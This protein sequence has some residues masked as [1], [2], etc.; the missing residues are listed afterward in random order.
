MPVLP[1]FITDPLWEQFQALLPERNITH[2]LGCHRPRIP[3]RVVFDKLL[4]RL[5]LGGTYQQHADESCSATTMRARRDEW[6]RA[7]VFEQLH[8]LAL[9]AYDQAVGLDLHDLVVDGCIVKAPCGGENT[10]RSPVDRGKS[11]LKRSVLV[12]G[13]G[14]PVGWV[15]A[16]AN[17][18][19]SP[20]LRPTLE[21][22]A[23]LG[24]R[25]PEAITV[26]LDAGYDSAG[27]RELLAELGCT[28][29]ITPRGTFLPINRTHRW[30]VERT[31]SWHNRGFATLAKVTDRRG[32]VQNAWVALA[33]AII[34]I[35]RLVRQ[36][37]IRYRW[38][39]R[40]ARCP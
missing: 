16:G 18:N 14:I 13:G 3:D 25:L 5:V 9:E 38:D 34:I 1:T 24:F 32:I 6:I 8:H 31:N 20:L 22:L 28:P 19:D 11:G 15:L 29:N 39:G 27:T 30:V 23:V 17:R 10:G 35:R 37:W 7:G 21:T 2:P 12:D 26:H 40:P 4:A 36:S 33:S